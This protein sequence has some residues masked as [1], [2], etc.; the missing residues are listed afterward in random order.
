MAESPATPTEAAPPPRK[1]RFFQI[2]LSTAIVLMFVAAALVWANVREYQ[3]HE[4]DYRRAFGWPLAVYRF[5]RHQESGNNNRFGMPDTPGWSFQNVA[6]NLAITAVM[7]AGSAIVSEFRIR[8][9]NHTWRQVHLSTMILLMIS[10]GMLLLANFR[11]EIYVTPPDEYF[12]RRGWPC[13]VM[14]KTQEWSIMHRST[15]DQ[16]STWYP[17]EIAANTATSLAILVTLTYLCEALI[18]LRERRHE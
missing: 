9:R 14:T 7:L 16:R 8:R 12:L 17:M 11:L 1:R 3:E 10:C 15:L 2:H 13:T 18:R 5:P 4:P 6:G